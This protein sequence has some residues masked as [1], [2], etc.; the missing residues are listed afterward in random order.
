MRKII[1]AAAAG[2]AALTLSACSEKT[3]DAAAETADA[4]MAEV[5]TEKGHAKP[6]DDTTPA[7][8]IDKLAKA[9]AEANGVSFHM[10]YA[11]VTKSGVGAEL[12][13]Q[14]RNTAN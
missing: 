11:E 8:K 2:A 10:A 9:H 13:A 3:E 1:L 14:M 7:A 5:Y 6:D 12:L 4:A